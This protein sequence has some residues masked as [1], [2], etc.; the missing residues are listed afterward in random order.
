M[1]RATVVL[2]W[3]AVVF[4]VWSCAA[5]QLAP[6]ESVYEKDAIKI[7]VKADRQ[8]NLSEGRPHTLVVCVYQLKDPNGLNQL[9]G[10]EDGLYKLLECGLF[11]STVAGAKRLI[12]QP[13]QDITFKLDRAQGARYVAVAAGYYR[14]EKERIV[15]VFEI[16]VVIEKKGFIKRS[17]LKKLGT[18]EIDLML[19]PQ[20]IK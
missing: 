15:R 2:S 9:A 19:G 18:L 10:D 16:P 20:Q 11:D 8:L 13:G 1:R 6:P 3:L 7:H 17:K 12:V 4:L 14:I 5:K